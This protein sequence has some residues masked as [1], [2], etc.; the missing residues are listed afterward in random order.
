VFHLHIPGGPRSNDDRLFEELDVLAA[1]AGGQRTAFNPAPAV[2]EAIYTVNEDSAG[3]FETKVRALLQHAGVQNVT[4]KRVHTADAHEAGDGTVDLSGDETFDLLQ[5][6]QR[7]ETPLGPGVISNIGL[8]AARYGDRIELEP[9]AITV[10]LEDP[11]P[12]EPEEVTVCMCKL[13][14]DDPKHEAIIRKEFARLWPPIEKEAPEDIHMLMDV[15]K[16][17][18]DMEKVRSRFEQQTMTAHRVASA[19]LRHRRQRRIFQD[20]VKLALHIAEP[21]IEETT[22]LQ[23]GTVLTGMEGVDLDEA[24]VVLKKLTMKGPDG[25]EAGQVYVLLYNPD[26]DTM[27]QLTVPGDSKFMGHDGPGATGVMPTV[28]DPQALD[29]S[30]LHPIRLLPNTYLPQNPN[31]PSSITDTVWRPTIR[32]TPI[33]YY[34]T[35][36][37]FQEPQKKEAGGFLRRPDYHDPQEWPPTSTVNYPT[38]DTVNPP[39][40]QRTRK[41]GKDAYDPYDQTPDMD[42]TVDKKMEELAM[43]FWGDYQHYREQKIP[44]KGNTLDI[45]IEDFADVFQ[46]RSELSD[47]EMAQLFNYFVQIGMMEESLLHKYLMRQ[48]EKFRQLNTR[49]HY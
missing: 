22:D 17:E 31:Y 13:G 1:V 7:V 47:D 11:E 35:E 5:I 40:K 2:T 8:Q 9:P 36:E 4:L 23:P 39:E 18:E 30:E 49:T 20:F 24:G 32:Q 21:A 41:R 45:D 6:G 15:K 38:P 46:G 16:K 29:S 26:S 48:D 42:E 27:R 44:G 43:K 28:Y 37:A 34:E 25:E 33:R 19:A 3:A 12:G 10:K 14:L